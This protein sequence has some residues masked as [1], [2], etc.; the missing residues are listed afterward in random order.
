[1]MK[2][3]PVICTTLMI[4]VLGPRDA[5]VKRIRFVEDILRGCIRTLDKDFP[6]EP[7]TAD[8][9]FLPQ[10]RATATAERQTWQ[11]VK[12]RCE[13]PKRSSESLHGGRRTSEQL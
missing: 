4:E 9:G 11:E 8:E 6:N 12:S 1:M 3:K 7:H 13:A 5:T 2:N 10:A